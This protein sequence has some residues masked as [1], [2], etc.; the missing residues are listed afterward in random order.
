MKT[1]IRIII[2]L[3]M[4]LHHKTASR[5]YFIGL[6]QTSV[7]RAKHPPES[8]KFYQIHVIIACNGY[9][10]QLLFTWFGGGNAH[11]LL[12]VLV[13]LYSGYFL[14]YLSGGKFFFG[15]GGEASV[16]ESDNWEQLG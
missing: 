5:A 11:S 16:F 4:Y 10:I 1:N 15:G 12:S 9:Y 6:S 8:Q 3:Y 2:I 13:I 14:Y 7:C